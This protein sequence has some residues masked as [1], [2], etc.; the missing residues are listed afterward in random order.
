MVIRGSGR[1]AVAGIGAAFPLEVSQEELWDGFFGERYAG[2]PVAERIWRRSGVASR[3]GVVVPMKE[4]VTGWGTAARMERFREEAPPLAREALGRALAAAG[5]GPADL[6]LLAVVTCTGYGTPGLD[7]AVARD[8]GMD[9]ALQRLQ[10]GHMGCYAA[11]PGLAAVADA[12][13][14]RGLAAGLVC[15]ELCSLH[16]Q[17]PADGGTDQVVAHALFSDA[18]AAAVVLPGGAGLEVVDV[19]ARTDPDMAHLMTWEITDRG[20]LMGLSPE[21]PAAVERHL[22]GLVDDLLEANGLARPDVVGWAIHP[23]GPRVVES[24]AVRLGLGEE[25]VADSTAVLR[26][27]GNCSSATILLV[28]ER[29]I[30]DGVSPGDPVVCLAFGP[31]LTLYAALLRATG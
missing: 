12:A 10:V 5:V 31:G 29:L 4:D 30:A 8:L 3:H 21:V 18:A 11:I 16:V 1:A 25:D 28:V 6:G 23:G 20:F 2:R 7:V 26:D 9:P 15:V 24:A 27:H 13:G 19:A 14:A 17:P 22:P